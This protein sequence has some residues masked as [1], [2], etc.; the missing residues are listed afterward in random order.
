MRMK[1]TP[2]ISAPKARPAPLLA[3]RSSS[4]LPTGWAGSPVSNVGASPQA[5]PYPNCHEP[6][7]TSV[8]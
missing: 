8:A 5:E 6:A 4:V 1:R 2:L 7:R 3:A